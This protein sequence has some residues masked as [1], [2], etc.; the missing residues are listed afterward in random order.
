M[1]AAKTWSDP[2]GSASIR[3]KDLDQLQKYRFGLKTADFYLCRTCGGYVG[4]VLSE[5]N[6]MWSTLNLRLSTLALDA[7]RA[8]YGAENAADRISRRR[9]A[10]TPTVVVGPAESATPADA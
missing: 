8:S 1:H 2:Q 7:I 5:G 10:W 3:V 6:H 4:A 9:Q